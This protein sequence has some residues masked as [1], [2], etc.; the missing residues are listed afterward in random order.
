MFSQ[1]KRIFMPGAIFLA[2]SALGMN[3]EQFIN[4]FDSK[5][6]KVSCV[7]YIDS[8]ADDELEK[9]VQEVNAFE[10]GWLDGAKHEKAKSFLKIALSTR[11]GY[12]SQ[13]KSA[14]PDRIYLLFR[15]CVKEVNSDPFASYKMRTCLR[16]YLQKTNLLVVGLAFA[17]D[18]VKGQY[19][20][21]KPYL[22]P[23]VCKL[24]DEATEKFEKQIKNLEE[25]SNAIL[26]GDIQAAREYDAELRI[27]DYLQRAEVK[28]AQA[29]VQQLC[30]SLKSEKSQENAKIVAAKLPDAIA[31]L[32]N[33]L[34]NEE[35]HYQLIVQ[36]RENFMKQLIASGVKK[37]DEIIASMAKDDPLLPLVKKHRHTF[38]T[39]TYFPQK[40][41]LHQE[42]EKK[43]LED[44]QKVLVKAQALQSPY[45]EGKY[46]SK[47]KKLFKEIYSGMK[48]D[49]VKL[50]FETQAEANKEYIPILFAA[51][52]VVLGVGIPCKESDYQP[53]L[54]KYTEEI[55]NPRFD[56]EVKAWRAKHKDLATFTQLDTHGLPHRIFWNEEKFVLVIRGRMALAII[57]DV[58]LLEELAKIEK[59]EKI[60]QQK[61][62]R[63]EKQKQIQERKKELNF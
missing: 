19:Q 14:N 25:S 27:A 2:V 53:L 34:K 63:L 58:Q 41:E 48:E 33:A 38:A 60:Q 37:Y 62:E 57:I 55:G 51:D 29:A 45:P 13:V 7:Q 22:N 12:L 23:E 32:Q 40:I 35:A 18:K 49:Y 24:I 36:L 31:Q 56:D 42:E 50:V 39:Y 28:K 47:P 52:G 43:Q 26:Q 16:F 17:N 15:K 30:E 10:P 20:F 1:I 54:A 21:I 8:L 44:A 61:K 59:N 46:T 5:E 9:F 6:K 3:A 11:K 4:D